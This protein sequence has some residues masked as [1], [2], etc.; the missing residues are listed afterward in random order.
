V[1]MA[2]A[3]GSEMLMLDE[4]AAGLNGGDVDRLRD[5]LVRLRDEGRT[6]WIV[7]HHMELVMAVCD[8]V[9]VLDAG[10]VIAAGTPDEVMAHPRVLEAYLG[11]AA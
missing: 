2:V 9:L 1:A 6:V 5:D 11:G 7:E 8:R 3:T 10:S 4:P